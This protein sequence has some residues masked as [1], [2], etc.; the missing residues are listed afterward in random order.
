M[1]TAYSSIIL[2]VMDSIMSGPPLSFLRFSQMGKVRFKDPGN[3]QQ[4]ISG[5]QEQNMFQYAADQLRTMADH[6]TRWF[7]SVFVSSGFLALIRDQFHGLIL[8][9]AFFWLPTLWTVSWVCGMLWAVKDG[10]FSRSKAQHSIWKLVG[11]CAILVIAHAFRH[12]SS[13][14]SYPAA[15]IEL[16]CIFTEGYN[17]LENAAGLTDNTWLKKMIGFSKVRVQDQLSRLV[18]AVSEIKDQ[19]A[20]AM[21]EVQDVK[22]QVAEV[23]AEVQAVVANTVP[24]AELMVDIDSPASE[25]AAKS[26]HTAENS[27]DTAES[28]KSDPNP[29]N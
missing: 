12:F 4:Y 17:A 19:H 7:A 23:K 6:S 16:A 11:Y 8:T 26:R 21:V 13:V 15:V 27:T 10:R 1:L 22:S 29:G 5:G 24:L 25:S 2:K 18:G 3:L 9:E 20:E 14:G 28:P